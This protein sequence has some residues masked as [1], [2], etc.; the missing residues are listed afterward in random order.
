MTRTARFAI[1][2]AALA[3][4]STIAGTIAY[5]HDDARAPSQ[6]LRYSVH[7]SPFTLVDIGAKGPSRG[8][9]IVSDDQIFTPSGRKAGRDTQACVITKLSP[10][11]AEC[12]LTFVFANGTITAQYMGRQPPHKIAAVTGGTGRY[13]GAR[14]ELTLVESGHDNSPHNV[15]TF[16]LLK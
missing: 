9:E 7:F 16:R 6:Q 12:T 1:T 5:G 3:C 11:E 4:V 15:L 14:G 13:I 8:D 2:V 10:L